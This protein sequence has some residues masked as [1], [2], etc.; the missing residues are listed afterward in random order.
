MLGIFLGYILFCQYLFTHHG[1]VLNIVYPL[2]VLLLVYLSI[3]AQRYFAETKQKRFIKNAFSTYLAPSVVR[4]LID[5]PENLELGGEERE[6]TAFFSDV[7]GF[8]SISE[9]LGPTE[10]VELLNEFLTEMTDIILRN[11]G[12]VDKFEGDAIIAFF[13]APNQL[14]DHATRACHASVQMQ[15]HL[16][17]LRHRWVAAGKPALKMRIGVNSGRAVVGNMGSASRM[18]YT[19]MGDMVNTAARL[20][21][22]NKIYGTYTLMGEETFRHAG[23][24]FLWR[25]IDTIRVVGRQEPM[26]IYE[27]LAYADAVDDRLRQISDEYGRGLQAYRRGDWD[28]AIDCFRRA[29]EIDPTDGPS[30]TLLNRCLAFK[31]DPPA[32]SWDRS[33]DIRVK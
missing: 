8:T 15:Q 16:D 28:R 4:Q 17:E 18:D 7:Q 11:E 2:S 33:Y 31:H 10:L 6:I 27:L 23:N 13:G 24:L 14:D 19:M 12:T 22:V 26:D 3:T 25:Q 9:N 5:S 30:G 21:G 1:L 20:E 32:D 29:M